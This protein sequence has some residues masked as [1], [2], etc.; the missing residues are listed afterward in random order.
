MPIS[1]TLKRLLGEIKQ[2]SE[3]LKTCHPGATTFILK[4]LFARIENAISVYN[5]PG[6]TSDE[7]RD[8]LPLFRE[9]LSVFISLYVTRRANET[10]MVGL[11]LF[12]RLINVPGLINYTD[13][14]YTTPVIIEIFRNMP[15][16]KMHD[17]YQ[18]REMKGKFTDI[19]VKLVDKINWAV[20]DDRGETPLL[21]L[22]RSKFCLDTQL[23]D[24]EYFTPLCT[25]V[26][27]AIVN[28][29]SEQ[30]I[31]G[32]DAVGNCPL[33]AA[34]ESRYP[35]EIIKLLIDRGAK[36]DF[37]SPG[38]RSIISRI[39]N[40]KS[41]E[42]R[43]LEI[44]L[45]MLGPVE[46]AGN[47]SSG[48]LSFFNGLLDEIF[49]QKGTCFFREDCALRLNDV[50]GMLL[51]KVGSK[52][53]QNILKHSYISESLL[54]QVMGKIDRIT[55]I[56][57]I[58]AVFDAQNRTDGWKS[59]RMELLLAK[60]DITFSGNIEKFNG[61]LSRVVSEK[62]SDYESIT[63]SLG[64]LSLLLQKISPKDV[65][66]SVLLQA[67]QNSS[68]TQVE[69]LLK[70][71][72][73]PDFGQLEEA[74]KVGDWSIFSCLLGHMSP[75]K[76]AAETQQALFL[77]VIDTGSIE[78]IRGLM[79][80]PGM[81]DIDLLRAA[82][83]TKKPAI[84]G[85]LSLK[86]VG[87]EVTQ[88]L[89]LEAIQ[90]GSLEMV[91]S[92]LRYGLMP[93][94]SVLSYIIKTENVEL[95]I[96]N[97]L[98][99][100]M[101][102]PGKEPKPNSRLLSEAMQ[103]KTERLG[104]V[105]SL[106][107]H[108]AKLEGEG[109]LLL[110]AVQSGE[111]GIVNALLDSGV[112]VTKEIIDEALRAQDTFNN[113]Q[114]ILSLALKYFL[115]N[116]QNW[117]GLFE[118]YG[119]KIC[120]NILSM[121]FSAANSYP[122]TSVGDYKPLLEHL[123]VVGKISVEQ[124]ME[125]LRRMPTSH[126]TFPLFMA[127]AKTQPA[128]RSF[129]KQILQSPKY[130]TEYLFLLGR[131]VS[132]ESIKEHLDRAY[133]FQNF[134]D[135]VQCASSLDTYQFKGII[136]F[137]D[138][139]PT[140][141]ELLSCIPDSPDRAIIYLEIINRGFIETGSE[142][143]MV[144]D[145]ELFC[146]NTCRLY[147]GSTDQMIGKL[148][149][150]Y[151]EIYKRVGCLAGGGDRSQAM[152]EQIAFN[153]WK[154]TASDNM[155]NT[156]K[157]LSLLLQCEEG[158]LSEGQEKSVVG[159]FNELMR[160]LSAKKVQTLDI[161]FSGRQYIVKTGE[162]TTC[163]IKNSSFLG[164]FLGRTEPIPYELKDALLRLIHNAINE[165]DEAVI[166]GYS[167]SKIS[168]PNTLV[169]DLTSVDGS[170]TE[171]KLKL[172]CALGIKPA[173]LPVVRAAAGNSGAPAPAASSSA[174][175]ATVGSG[176][177]E[178]GDVALICNAMREKNSKVILDLA[179]ERPG[180]LNERFRLGATLESTPFIT[181]VCLGNVPAV[182]V[183]LKTYNANPNQG[184]KSN[185]VPLGRAIHEAFRMI[186]GS[187]S[188][189]GS[190]PFLSIANLLLD[191]GAQVDGDVVKENIRGG[192]TPVVKLRGMIPAVRD[193]GC[194]SEIKARWEQLLVR[195]E[196]VAVAAKAGSVPMPAVTIGYPS[197]CVASPQ[198]LV[199]DK[200]P[201]EEVKFGPQYLPDGTDDRRAH[202]EVNS[203]L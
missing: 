105:I 4:E 170:S 155:G 163:T 129:F 144:K 184:D 62:Q 186:R 46:I 14:T 174:S 43:L 143:F 178:Q 35:V 168:I 159:I 113:K 68:R 151:R 85:C 157:Y 142:H 54:L 69:C 192:E 188:G 5:D 98:L 199:A 180:I 42:A 26:I 167:Q 21:A 124:F 97:C 49:R 7:R 55:D 120:H 28:K 96:F 194:S 65:D 177:V 76:E 58:A 182:S 132:S 107:K 131:N 136:P 33:S 127:I 67:I 60:F 29:T 12:E 77:K 148:P 30:I 173:A 187:A 156:L 200:A 162:T 19:L 203:T 40:L 53:D 8:S 166:R 123:I 100:T 15:L 197:A 147:D 2:Q 16:E 122:T 24:Q 195:V 87:A 39:F 10:K 160:A 64:I 135:G 171:T 181:L 114:I 140:L 118:N 111:I 126:V 133:K 115:Q 103:A 137:I 95:T 48:V 152:E 31:S 202:D 193:A 75:S 34:I 119:D 6:V 196:A 91:Q 154:E 109:N 138:P 1:E 74:I 146:K 66:R 141:R 37:S 101:Y 23:I 63:W 57:V 18:D 179:K 52:V 84:V 191:S 44:M 51:N 158:S 169:L 70:H 201:K 130:C 36:L 94:D 183:A 25:R 88:G 59:R 73:K 134:I 47:D 90:V 78:M 102:P 104:K 125:L 139:Q 82:I 175:A 99:D 150:I 86:D 121:F 72:V 189:E 106:L 13:K 32:T 164:F 50:I 172:C 176:Q 149:P 45:L 22:F 108:G 93:D 145:L 112:T 185:T 165:P 41:I 71:G 79:G 117:R 9:I 56:G 81:H 3:Q 153:V 20:V 128:G 116:P 89:F 38:G 11:E 80:G 190:Q 92:L 161:T 198:Y 110:Q 83:R 61:V 27:T 17:S